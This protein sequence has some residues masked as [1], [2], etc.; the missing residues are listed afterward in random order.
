MYNKVQNTQQKKNAYNDIP[1]FQLPD[2]YGNTITESS[3]QKNTSI[4]F[5]FFNPDCELCREEM[6]QINLN[7]AAFAHYPMVF[8]ST[9]PAD[10]LTLFLDEINFVPSSNMLFLVDEN[11]DLT[12]KM[13]VHNS[14]TSYIYNQQG[15]LIKRF[16]GPVKIETLIK[17]LSE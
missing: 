11:E 2:I 7:Q 17:Y 13:E 3:L 5:L 12:N 10:I 16:A 15:K 9:L 14:P 1:A 6:E 4:L 8:F